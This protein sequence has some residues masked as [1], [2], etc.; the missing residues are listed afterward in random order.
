MN[1][2][3]V[4]GD[5]EVVINDF[6]LAQAHMSSILQQKVRSWQVLPWRLVALADPHEERARQFAVEI[7]ETFDSI[8]ARKAAAKPSASRRS[9]PTSS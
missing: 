3:L 5:A 2:A 6:A 7:I 8:P 1:D 9:A 4:E